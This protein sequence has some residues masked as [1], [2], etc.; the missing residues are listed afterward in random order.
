MQTLVHRHIVLALLNNVF[1][2]NNA[3]NGVGG[4][5]TIDTAEVCPELPN[6]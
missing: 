6:N 1:Q 4:G 3:L 2:G 5:L